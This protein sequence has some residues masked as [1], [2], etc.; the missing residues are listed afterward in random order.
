[1]YTSTILIKYAFKISIQFWSRR[2]GLGFRVI[3]CVTV[4]A[5]VLVRLSVCVRV[6]VRA[7]M[8]CA[9]VCLVRFLCLWRVS[10]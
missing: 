7:C 5:R 10:F 6:R 2:A 8:R 9:S 1:M 3:D 4:C